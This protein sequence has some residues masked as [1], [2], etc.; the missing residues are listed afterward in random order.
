MAGG[1]CYLESI[2]VGLAGTTAT[3]RRGRLTVAPPD[4]DGLTEHIHRDFENNSSH[5]LSHTAKALSVRVGPA[6]SH[7]VSRRPAAGWKSRS[8]VF[9]FE[10]EQAQ[11][12]WSQRP[13]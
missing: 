7:A 4:T 6:M 9:G 2:S 8:E 13:C 5:A 11:Q 12:W 1:Y 10:R 3:S